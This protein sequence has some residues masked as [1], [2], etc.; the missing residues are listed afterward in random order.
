MHIHHEMPQAKIAQLLVV[1]LSPAELLA[2]D[3]PESTIM[4]VF[5]F[6][7]KKKSP[8]HFLIIC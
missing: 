8:E 2:S 7:L 1:N 5:M 6:S 4:Y 3:I